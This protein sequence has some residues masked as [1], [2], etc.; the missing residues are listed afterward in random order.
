MS[1]GQ[2]VLGQK[3]FDQD[4]KIMFF[5]GQKKIAKRESVC[6]RERERESR[7]ERERERV[8]DW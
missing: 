3:S 4:N 6:V 8:G 7:G 2:M 1:F 5:N